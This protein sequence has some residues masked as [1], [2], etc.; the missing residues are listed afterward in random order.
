MNQ[1]EY[2]SE[3]QDWYAPTTVDSRLPVIKRAQ[4][5]EIW[6]I[7]EKRYL[8]FFSQAGVANIGHNHPAVIEAVTK[9]TEKLM[10]I[11]SQDFGYFSEEV[12][13]IRLAEEL[14]K[15]ISF[16]VKFIPEVSGATAVNAAVKL[17]LRVRPERKIFLAFKNAFHGR[18]GYALDLTFSKAVQKKDFPTALE[19][20]HTAF[21]TDSASVD[22]FQKLL[23]YYVDT[24]EV[25]ALV[26][27]P[28][29][30]E[31]G[32]MQAADK[33]ALKEIIAICQKNNILVIADEIQSGFGRTGK[34]W[35][36]EHYDFEPNIICIGKAIAAGLPMAM[37]AYKKE[38]EQNNLEQGWHSSTYAGG[39]IPV[40][41]ALAVLRVI[42]QENLI[43]KAELTGIYLSGFLKG[44][45]QLAEQKYKKFH[46]AVKGF[47]LMQGVEF[48][49]YTSRFPYQELREKVFE[50]C[51]ANGLLLLP[52][53]HSQRNPTLRITP[54]LNIPYE[55]LEEG[56]KILHQAIFD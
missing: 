13:P 26:L 47:G 17:L 20:Y 40:A 15:T 8:D 38:L 43:Q 21:P 11:A 5:A 1:K 3:H 14:Q 10:F 9:Q 32:G 2:Y 41:A 30:G 27:E 22:E 16:P 36:F 6:D 54:P 45:T 18:H 48:Q 35:A 56:L 28:I 42:K 25:N 39:P 31:G 51:L 52:A 49:T 12:S 37:V 55:N 23:K 24:D 29:Q 7:E 44:L 50:K 46:L 4:S 33:K 34:F 53:G 19:V